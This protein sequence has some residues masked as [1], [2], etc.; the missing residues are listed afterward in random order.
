[1]E[2]IY[3]D[4]DPFLGFL[5]KEDGKIDCCGALID[6][7]KNGDIT[8]FTSALTFVEV[9]KLKGHDPIGSD[10]IRD[11]EL[12]FAEPFIRVAELDRFIAE[13]ARK[14]VW[15]HGIDPR[16][17]VHVA[18]AIKWKVPL[19]NTYDGALLK[20]DRKIGNPPLII[21]QPFVENLPLPFDQ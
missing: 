7:A 3:W 11:L 15:N 18:T 2:K 8:I 6:K 19:L 12:F 21:K 13:E 4:S 5:N 20:K 17:S 9:V 1:M 10:R 16:D 14:L